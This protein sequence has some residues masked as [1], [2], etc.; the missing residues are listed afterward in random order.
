VPKSLFVLLRY[1]NFLNCLL[2]KNVFQKELEKLDIKLE[3]VAKM[4]QLSHLPSVGTVSMNQIG[5]W[6]NELEMLHL[7]QFALRCYLAAIKET[8]GP[9]CKVIGFWFQNKNTHCI[10]QRVLAAAS[11]N[12]KSHLSQMGIFTLSA[13]HAFCS[14]RAA[15][16]M[17]PSSAVGGSLPSWL[18]SSFTPPC[19]TIGAFSSSAEIDQALSFTP[20]SPPQS[21]SLLVQIALPTGQVTVVGVSESD[22]V[23]TVL[24]KAADKVGLSADGCFLMLKNSTKSGSS[25][26]FT[27]EDNDYIFPM[28]R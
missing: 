25:D 27:P 14:T 18:A 20:R 24:R 10:F 16:Q 1:Y 7:H 6:E 8:D 28:V 17:H 23:A 21:K 2:D 11:T 22:T 19:D 13:M 9:S 3:T 26:C 4:L 5:D 15:Q 12:T